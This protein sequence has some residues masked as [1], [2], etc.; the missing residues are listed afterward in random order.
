MKFID[1]DFFESLAD[2]SFGDMYSST[3]VKPDYDT[4]VRVFDEFEKPTFFIETHRLP[5]LIK[6]LYKFESKCRIIA[7]NSDYSFGGELLPFIPKYVEKIWCQNYN[8]EETDIISS[9]PIGL[10]RKLWFPEQRKQ[11]VLFEMMDFDV[12][13]SS[14]VYMNFDTKTNPIRS[15]I[16]ESLKDKPYITTEMIGNGGDYRNYLDNLKGHKFIISPPGNGIDCHRNWETIYC[17]SIPIILDSPFAR[18]VFSDLPV[19][20]LDSYEQLDFIDLEHTYDVITSKHFDKNAIY[21]KY[22]NFIRG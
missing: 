9:I 5:Q 22:L 4:L 14:R 6:E 11:E 8:F 2:F 3:I 7:H 17:G 15:Q 18:N 12:E 16:Y 21:D 10:E 20:I 13:K 19:L 1:G